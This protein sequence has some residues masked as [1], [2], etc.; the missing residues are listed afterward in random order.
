MAVE[1][2]VINSKSDGITVIIES[3]FCECGDM[4]MLG[5][6]REAVPHVHTNNCPV[7]NNSGGAE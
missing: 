1:D 3:D 2:N 4:V 6:F 5:P 7:I